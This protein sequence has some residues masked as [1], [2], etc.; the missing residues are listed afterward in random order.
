VPEWFTPRQVARARRISPAKVYAFIDAGVL[1]AIDHSN[2][3]HIRPRWRI[4]SAALEA[5]DQ[6]RS[7][8][9]AIQPVPVRRQRRSEVEERQ[10]Y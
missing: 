3:P 6:A 1:E 5:F 10:W 9:A 4:S 7:N 8:R 2:L